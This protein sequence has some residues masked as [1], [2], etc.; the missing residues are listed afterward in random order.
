MSDFG[1]AFTFGYLTT[2]GYLRNPFNSFGYY[3]GYCGGYYGGGLYGVAAARSM[4]YDTPYIYSC[5]ADLDSP[6]G[7]SSPIGFVNYGLN[8]PSGGGFSG[9][10]YNPFGY[11]YNPMGFGLIGGFG[12]YC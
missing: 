5:Y 12:Y 7:L 3:G 8:Y 2:R 10:G 6:S 1:S 11:A 9:V 4:A